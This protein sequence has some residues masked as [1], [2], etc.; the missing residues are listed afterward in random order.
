ML[1]TFADSTGLG[2]ADVDPLPGS[3]RGGRV[4]VARF[5]RLQVEREAAAH[6]LGNV[7]AAFHAA[8]APVAQLDAGL[9]A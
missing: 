8:V 5:L 1:S 7:A 4:L 9:P 3:I 6:L 2:T